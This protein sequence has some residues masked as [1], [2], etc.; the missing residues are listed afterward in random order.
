MSKIIPLDH[1]RRSERRWAARFSR[2]TEAATPRNRRS[3]MTGDQITG[4]GESKRKTQRIEV[5]GAKP[6]SVV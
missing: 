5:P 3:E 6:L 4:L 1:Q 2:P